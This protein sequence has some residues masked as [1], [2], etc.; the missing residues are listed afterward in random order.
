MKWTTLGAIRH[1]K[2]SRWLFFNAQAPPSFPL[3]EGE[4]RA[5]PVGAARLFHR[6]QQCPPRWTPDGLHV[7]PHEPCGDGQAPPTWPALGKASP[8]LVD[9][10]VKCSFRYNQ[11]MF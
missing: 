9:F 8:L 5:P 11:G 2:G 6:L 10:S 3:G 1:N 7:H 4:Q